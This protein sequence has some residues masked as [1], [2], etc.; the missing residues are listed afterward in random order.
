MKTVK[1][2]FRPHLE[3]FKRYMRFY[4]T[5]ASFRNINVLRSVLLTQTDRGISQEA[6]SESKK[7]CL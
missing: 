1:L 6:K 2:R 4:E 5:W 7:K 3:C